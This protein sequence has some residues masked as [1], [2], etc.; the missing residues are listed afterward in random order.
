LG[1][2]HSVEV[3]HGGELAGG[4]YGVAIGGLFAGES[5]FHRVRDASK[6]ALAHLVRHL[7]ERGYRLFDIQQ[8]TPHTERL[9]AV[10]IP[11]AEFL[12]R[13]AEALVAPATFGAIND[14]P[15][16]AVDPGEIQ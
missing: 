16:S 6:V 11:R 4:T 3:W 10:D 12:N 7:R 15:Q 9:G 5:M 14:P 2:A 1:H 8:L 13:L